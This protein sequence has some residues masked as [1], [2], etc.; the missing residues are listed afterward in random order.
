MGEQSIRIAVAVVLGVALVGVRDAGPA[1]IGALY[2]AAVTVSLAVVDARERRL[3]NAVVLPGYAFAAVGL[4]WGWL[5]RGDPPWIALGCGLGVLAL[6]GVL[7]AG[8]GL[9]MGDVKL[10]GLLA[11]AL[12]A[13]VVGRG[14]P[15]EAAGAVLVWVVAACAVAAVAGVAEVWMGAGAGAEIALGPILLGSFWTVTLVW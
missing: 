9:G 3:P 8:G 2:V 6:V 11:I 7:S 10:A 12:A 15:G 5:A 13:V 14:P 1:V 4:L